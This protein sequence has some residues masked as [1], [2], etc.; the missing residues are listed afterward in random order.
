MLLSNKALYHAA[1]THLMSAVV[2]PATAGIHYRLYTMDS[3]LR[4]NDNEHAV[5]SHS[6][7]FTAC[8]GDRFALLRSKLNGCLTIETGRFTVILSRQSLELTHRK[9]N[10]GQRTLAAAWKA[11]NL[12]G[13]DSRSFALHARNYNRPLFFASH[14]RIRRILVQN[15]G[16]PTP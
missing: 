10:L 3:H 15:G 8:F 7:S 4:R 11:K 13:R 5:R 6:A 16:A 1:Y 9:A 2:I 14:R 12:L